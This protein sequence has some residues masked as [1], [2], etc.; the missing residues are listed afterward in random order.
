[1][2]RAA[3]IVQTLIMLC[4]TAGVASAQTREVRLNITV[5]DQTNLILPAATVRLTGEEAATR[6]R[7]IEPEQTSP[8][9]VATF[10]R[11]AAGRYT[12]EAEFPGFDTGVVKDVRLRPGDNRQTIVLKIQ[13]LQD[14]ITVG[15]DPQNAASDRRGPA[16]GTALTRDQIDALS[17]DPDEMKKQIQDMAG[18]GAV[19]RVDSFEGSELP[20]KSQIKS[21]HVTRDGFAA[22]N[23][24]AGAFFIDIIT[25]PGVGQLRGGFQTRFRSGALSGRSPFTATK[26]PEQMQNYNLNLGGPVHSQRSSFSIGVNETM[27]YDTPNL[28]VAL[29]NQSR[30]EALSQ[31]AH[32][33][34]A[35]FNA[36]FDYA[37]TPD[38]TLRFSLFGNRAKNTNLGIGAYDLPERAYRTSDQNYTLRVQEAG[39]LGRRFFTNTRVQLQMNRSSS[40][41]AVEAPTIRVTEAFTSGGAQLAGGRRTRAV[42]VQSDLDY[43]RGIHSVRT[44]LNIDIGQHHSDATSNYLGTY[45]FASSADLEAGHPLSY[46]RRIGDPRIDYLHSQLGW[47]I[48]DDVRVSRRLT[49]S[50]GIRY[51]VQGHVSDFD[52]LGPRFGITWAP[53]KNAKTTLRGSAGIFYDWL[54][55]NTYEQAL[56]VDGYRQRELN[57]I[58]PAFPDPGSVGL[59]PAVNRYLLNEELHLAR[60]SRVSF[61]IDRAIA[62]RLRVGV[63]YAHVRGQGLLHGINENPPLNGVRPDPSFANVIEVVSGARSVQH[64]LTFNVNVGGPP[65]PPF[66]GNNGPLWNFKRISLNG[67]YTLGSNRNNTEGDFGTSPTGNIDDDWGP[68]AGDVRHRAFIGVSSQ[69]LRNFSASLNLNMSSAGRYTIRTGADDNNDGIFNDR[70]PGVGRNTE[71]TSGQWTLNGNF[72]YSIGFGKGRASGPGGVG[73]IVQGGDRPTVTTFTPPPARFRLQFFLQAQNLTNH[74]NYAGYSGTL[75]SPFFGQPTLVINPRKLDFMIGVGF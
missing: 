1:M 24:N 49:L 13:R 31:Q 73:V 46:T 58:D 26:G 30:S 23:H 28:K 55:T 41:S 3:R 61:G 64:A 51:E 68:T 8:Q 17:D 10:G 44:G 43:V 7:T 18:P 25:Q 47:Y 60:N 20:P 37:I 32:R 42:T 33:D 6:V 74:N 4:A 2:T 36:L 22:E 15:Q 21:I 19:I 53:F 27:S 39:P 14:A 72:S 45:T 40:E 75:T 34:N 38:Q 54:N 66:G 16:F 63:L 62:P 71:H 11:L 59:V 65:A 52:N 70:P 69:A 67:N 12:I 9:G 56:R 29:P 50:P 35:G 48:Q 5:V 57:I